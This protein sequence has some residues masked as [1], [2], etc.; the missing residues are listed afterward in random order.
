M[1]AGYDVRWQAGVPLMATLIM[2]AFLWLIF[3]IDWIG[4]TTAGP[5]VRYLGN[6]VYSYGDD[7]CE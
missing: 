6:G 5:G 7:E 1:H 3:Q 4:I 2:L